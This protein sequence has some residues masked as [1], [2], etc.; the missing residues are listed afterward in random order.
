MII[1]SDS[2]GR[3]RDDSLPSCPPLLSQYTAF[4]LFHLELSTLDLIYCFRYHHLSP[5]QFIDLL[6]SQLLPSR[7]SREWK[8][9]LSRLSS[10]CLLLLLLLHFVLH[11]GYSYLPSPFTSSVSI[12]LHCSII[13]FMSFYLLFRMRSGMS[14][15]LFPI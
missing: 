6:P 7:T 9:Q 11:L 12:S 3:K 4:V 2:M 14:S 15:Y 13:F 1:Y 8:K 5:H 10:S